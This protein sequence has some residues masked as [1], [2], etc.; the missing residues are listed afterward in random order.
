MV[1]R[2]DA[3]GAEVSFYLAGYE[4]DLGIFSGIGR[5]GCLSECVSCVI[6]CGTSATLLGLRF[7]PTRHDAASSASSLIERCR[8]LRGA[9]S[10]LSKRR[11]RAFRGPRRRMS[12]RESRARK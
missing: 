2:R 4:L 9:S 8:G 3:R 10:R 6:A 7:L 5:A 12:C 1:G 11:S